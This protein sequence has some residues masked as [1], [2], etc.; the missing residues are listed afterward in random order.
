MEGIYTDEWGRLPMIQKEVLLPRGEGGRSDLP[1]GDPEG[2]L[3][4]TWGLLR[5]R[6]MDP[7][8]GLVIFRKDLTLLKKTSLTMDVESGKSQ[9][10]NTDTWI[11]FMTT[12]IDVRSQC[13]GITSFPWVDSQDQG[14]RHRKCL[15]SLFS[16][17]YILSHGV[18]YILS[19]IRYVRIYSSE[20]YFFHQTWRK[21][22]I[23]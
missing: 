11:F 3:D 19:V 10:G 12:S 9:F 7:H 5:P 23:I 14:N 6:V 18:L 15:C 4:H 2:G 16:Q 21:E 20:E 1:Q 13:T 22:K 8:P 17:F